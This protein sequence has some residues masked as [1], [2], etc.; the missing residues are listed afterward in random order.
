MQAQIPAAAV[1]PG[2]A[3][4]VSDA[5]HGDRDEVILSDGLEQ[6]QGQGLG[7]SA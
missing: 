3:V 7:N 5:P 1:T 2:L 6:A 4:T